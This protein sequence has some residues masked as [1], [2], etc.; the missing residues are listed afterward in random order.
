MPTKDITTNM[1][2]NKDNSPELPGGNPIDAVESFN[3]LILVPIPG[4]MTFSWGY[5]SYEIQFKI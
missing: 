1:L 2:G 5:N 3:K 4:N